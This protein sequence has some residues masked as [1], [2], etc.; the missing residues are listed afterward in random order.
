MVTPDGRPDR[1][2]VTADEVLVLVLVVWLLLI[3]GRR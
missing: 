3:C 1:P 2:A